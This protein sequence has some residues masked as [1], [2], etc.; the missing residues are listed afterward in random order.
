MLSIK[1]K[2]AKL[3]CLV[4]LISF[5][6]PNIQSVSEAS[7]NNELMS[8]IVYQDEERIITTEIPKKLSNDQNFINKIKRDYLESLGD[9]SHSSIFLLRRREVTP[10]YVTPEQP[11]RPTR[12]LLST[13]RW[14]ASD[15]KKRL[16]AEKRGAEILKKAGTGTIAEATAAIL[17]ILGTGGYASLGRI[18]FN[19][20]T[21][22]ITQKSQKWLTE[23][24]VMITRGQIRYVE[25]RIYENLAGDYPKVFVEHVRVK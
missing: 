24:L 12:K 11:P 21:N 3:L 9:T 13:T 1:R 16:A 5:I 23:S 14:Y 2:T 22:Y 8:I 15:I 17:D 25:Q 20:Y 6:F 4:L 18:I 7:N 10:F 19:G